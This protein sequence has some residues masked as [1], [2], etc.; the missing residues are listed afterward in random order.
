VARIT[1]GHGHR[2]NF[3]YE[4]GEQNSNNT[5]HKQFFNKLHLFLSK[6]REEA[7][8]RGRSFVFDGGSGEDRSNKG[9][10]TEEKERERIFAGKS[11]AYSASLFCFLAKFIR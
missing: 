2:N 11:K 5:S 4:K 10:E 3:G 1:T 9:I 8:R 7:A 6:Q